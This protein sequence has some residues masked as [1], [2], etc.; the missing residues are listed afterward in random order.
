MRSNLFIQRQKLKQSTVWKTFFVGLFV[1]Q[2][3]KKSASPHPFSVNNCMCQCDRVV[4]DLLTFYSFCKSFFCVF[5]LFVRVSEF[6]VPHFTIYDDV[7]WTLLLFTSQNIVFVPYWSMSAKKRVFAKNRKQ[8]CEPLLLLQKWCHIEVL[9]HNDQKTEKFCKNGKNRRFFAWMLYKNSDKK[10]LSNYRLLQLL[11]LGKE[12]KS[13][14]LKFR[15]FRNRV[16]L[17]IMIF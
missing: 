2:S 17:N 6:F 15:F 14:C 8:M 7:F 4:L 5:F 12:I 16:L 13:H 11:L 3:S 1:R 10:G 9:L